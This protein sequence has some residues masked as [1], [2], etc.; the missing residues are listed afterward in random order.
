[1]IAPKA[2]GHTVRSE[3]MEGKGTPALS[4]CTRITPATA[5][6][7]ALAYGAGIGAARAAVMETTFKIET[8]T[9]LFGEP[10]R[11]VR[12]CYRFDAGRF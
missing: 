2:P 3:Y 7:V 6:D 4:L 9:D 11:T 5:L 1:M 8:E 10:G 12:R